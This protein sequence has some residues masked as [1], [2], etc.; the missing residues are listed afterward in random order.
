MNCRQALSHLCDMLYAQFHELSGT[1]QNLTEAFL[2][3]R[4]DYVDSHYPAP[5]SVRELML[6]HRTFL[7]RRCS[8]WL[9]TSL[10][11]RK[12]TLIRSACLMVVL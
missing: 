12:R 4:D 8:T 10:G 9:F 7:C 5:C 1:D 6:R 3:N 11:P 2:G